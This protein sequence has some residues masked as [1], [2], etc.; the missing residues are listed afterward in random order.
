MIYFYSNNSLFDVWDILSLNKFY[1]Q[2]LVEI[3]VMFHKVFDVHV[4]HYILSTCLLCVY[5]KISTPILS[6][7]S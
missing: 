5:I 6:Q 7:F 4:T 1:I 2:D 3:T